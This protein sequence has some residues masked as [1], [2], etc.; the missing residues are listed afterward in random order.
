MEPDRSIQL[1]E[2]SATQRLAAPYLAMGYSVSAAA[3]EADLVERT[4]DSWMDKPE[5][6]VYVAQVRAELIARYDEQ[7]EDIILSA[8]D[9]ERRAH[10]GEIDADSPRAKLAHDT[11]KSTA[12]PMARDRAKG[13]Q[14]GSAQNYIEQSK[15]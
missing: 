9:L 13:P 7:F 5:F 15:P 12:Y 4:V 2:P 11:L 14:A 1:W 3:R 6:R 10:M 8:I